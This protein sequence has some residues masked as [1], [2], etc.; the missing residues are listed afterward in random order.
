[1][2]RREWLAALS[3]RHSG[4]EGGRRA[5]DE[6]YW[7]GV[8]NLFTRGLTRKGLVDF[9]RHEPAEALRFLTRDAEL[10]ELRARP[11]FRRLPLT[12]W[13]VFLATAYRLSPPRR[14]L[15]AVAVPLVVVG[16]LRFLVFQG[17]PLGAHLPTLEQLV[18]LAATLLLFLL[19][20]ELMDKLSLKGDLE[21]A[22]QIQFGLL[23]FAPV[24]RP[25]LRVRSSMRPANTVGGDYFDVIELGG[26]RLA[27]ALG[28][29]AGKGMPA[30][31]LMALLQG[32]LQ[33]LISAG[34]RGARLISQLNDHLCA[35]IPSNRLITLFYGELELESG[36]MRYVNAGHNPP[37][38]LGTHGVERLPATG[39]ALGVVS[40]A[41][42]EERDCALRTGDRLLLYTD[43]VV[44][45]MNGRDEQ[46]GEERLRG[47]LRASR[48]LLPEP[49]IDGIVSAV[50]AHA[51]GVR[52][53]DDMTIMCVDRLA[54]EG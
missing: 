21:V 39:I 5:L 53:I 17:G 44:E 9:L 33:T 46:F 42:F 28:D 23:P 11:W 38:W 32:S 18:L 37:L 41:E 16:W 47:L 4:G 54:L 50:L 10:A 7:R 49:Q 15:F 2:S 36:V 30:A 14:L 3:E 29:V 24:D 1:M 45:A 43:G 6:D 52:P 34:L 19:I 8:R 20:L 35:H 40:P 25:G 51:G 48:D 13:R 31:L 26:G 27:L 22:R 12:V